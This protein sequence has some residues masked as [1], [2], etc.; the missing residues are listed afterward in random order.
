[1]ELTKEEFENKYKE[2]IYNPYTEAW[3]IMKTLRSADL[4]SDKTW[5]EY[6]KKCDDFRAKY[7]TEIGGSIYRVM[8]DNGDACRRIKSEVY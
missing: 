6:M 2:I 8:L 7:P 3:Q 1:M 5:E 4:E